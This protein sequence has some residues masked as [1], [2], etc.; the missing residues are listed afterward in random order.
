MAGWSWGED[1]G[2]KRW[3]RRKILRLYERR[4]A[5]AFGDQRYSSGTSPTSYRYTGQRQEAGKVGDDRPP[6]NLQNGIYKICVFMLR[7]LGR[8]RF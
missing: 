6:P 1:V 7:R 8:H 3:W 4:E 2:G 5:W